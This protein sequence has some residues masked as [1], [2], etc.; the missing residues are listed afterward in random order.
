[1]PNY[2]LQLFMK[3]SGS[4]SEVFAPEQDV[5]LVTDLCD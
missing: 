1:M 3:Y 4:E 5:T 2:L